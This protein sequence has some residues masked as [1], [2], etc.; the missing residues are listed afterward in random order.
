MPS[1]SPVLISYLSRSFLLAL[2]TAVL[3]SCNT[4]SRS[5]KQNPRNRKRFSGELLYTSLYISQLTAPASIR[6][7][8]MRCTSEVVFGKQNE[9]ESVRIPVYRHEATSLL[10]SSLCP[11][12]LTT[13]LYTSC[14]VAQALVSQ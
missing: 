4:S 3:Y 8:V 6:S 9:A 11:S 14:A 5:D 2:I 1:V 7:A 10:T 12:S 13:N